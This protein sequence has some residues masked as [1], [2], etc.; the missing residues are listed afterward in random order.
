M[1]KSKPIKKRENKRPSC[2]ACGRRMI[3]GDTGELERDCECLTCSVCGKVY[4]HDDERGVT[5]ASTD[6][7][8]ELYDPFDLG[9]CQSC[10]EAVE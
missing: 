8:A 7:L 5:V 6:E 3:K 4:R 1:S 2:A 9:R 10:W